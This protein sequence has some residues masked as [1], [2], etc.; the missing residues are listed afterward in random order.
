MRGFEGTGEKQQIKDENG[1]ELTTE[2]KEAEAFRGRMKRT[3]NISEQENENFNEDTEEMVR[4][5]HL[6]YRD[7]LFPRDIISISEEDSTATQEL[8]MII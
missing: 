6:L 2:R 8:K 3:F 7:R 5:W 1:L 4:M